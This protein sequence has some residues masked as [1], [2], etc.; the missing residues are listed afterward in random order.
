MRQLV[1]QF[2]PSITRRRD[3][4]EGEPSED[5]LQIWKS[6]LTRA[7]TAAV[8]IL[9]STVLAA[10]VDELAGL[11]LDEL[12]SIKLNTVYGSSR[13][14][15][16]IEDAP[17]L[18]TIVDADE[19]KKHG[20][21]TLAEILRSV[22][23]FYTTYDRNYTY[24]GV[25]GFSRPG[26][27]NSRV[28]LLIDGHRINDNV[29]GGALIGTE[30]PLDVDLI[31]RVE[32][33]RG[34][35]FSV[36][37]DNAVFAVVNVITKRGRDF[38][39]V[40]VSGE[41]GSLDSYKGRFTFG[42]RFE[43]DL[44]LMVSGSFY[45]SGGNERLYY[46]E[47]NTPTNNV[48]NG[49]AQDADY[50]RSVSTVAT[51]S[52]H[53]FTIQ[54]LFGSR[55]KGI[56]TGSYG[57]TF[58]DTRNRTIDEQ[59]YLDAK[60]EH[61]FDGDWDVTSR[62]YWDYYHYNGNYIYGPVMNVDY[63]YGESVGGEAHVN[64][65]LLDR[66]TLM[67]GAEFRTI[68]DL[69]QGNFDVDP[70]TVEMDDHRNC[71][72]WAVFA[73]GD[74]R[75]L[76][77]LLLS[78]GIRY[79]YY[80]TFGDK[81]S[82]RAG[83]IYNPFSVTT[84]KLLWGTAFRAPNAYELFYAGP[85]LKGNPSMQPEDITTYQFVLEQTLTEHIRG[86][87]TLYHYDIDNLINQEVDPADGLLFFGNMQKANANGS[88]IGLEANYLSGFRGRLSYAFQRTKDEQSGEE[89]SNSPQHLAKLGVIVP[90]W[91]D[92]FFTGFD[93]QYQSSVNTL[94]GQQ[95]GDFW[96]ANLTLFSQKLVKGLEASAS[97]YNLFDAHYR[98][99]GGPELIQDT[100]QQDGRSF[101][102]KLTYRF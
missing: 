16:R 71:D 88:E 75:I 72:N 13:Y 78:G 74:F 92:K 102:V 58:N 60:F 87:A 11:S 90:L 86:Y 8:C 54:G 96:V 55:E 47:Y 9:S 91:R 51:L 22:G 101:R 59:A 45:D 56:P 52:Y 53:D 69:N 30:F 48:N 1:I 24:L 97:I 20:Q 77:N 43:S 36:F 76:T 46:P 50:D 3:R 39:S 73:Q 65:L 66:H 4:A 12:S 2:R 26:D 38:G 27:Y 33:V 17:S 25:R 37:G 81:T 93:V 89:L 32:I 64:K 40:E 6:A 31:E 79:D 80:T 100:I 84:L 62:L 29:Y 67:A 15:Q 99:A 57:T 83:L 63:A 5:Y 10:S 68:Y 85:G 42:R 41:A 7:I 19:I 61:R 49:V 28:L 94:G 70:H 98:N 35:S 34:P 21:R 23:G 95:A 18:V 82:Y 44:E 14:V